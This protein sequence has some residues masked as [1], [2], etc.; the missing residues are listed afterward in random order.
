MKSNNTVIIGA[1]PAGL[2]AAL[3][4]VKKGGAPLVLEAGSEVGGIA[5]TVEYKDFRFDIGGHRFLTKLES[6]DHLWQQMLGPDFLQVKRSSRIYYNT[7]FFDYPLKVTNAL[8]NL[9]L[10]ESARII[11]SYSYSQLFPYL[12]E[13]TFEQW[14]CNR[15]GKHLYRIFFKT[16]TEKVWGIPCSAIRADWAAQRIKG[17]SMVSVDTNAL[18]GTRSAKTLTDQFQYPARGPGMMWN[19]F[20]AAV[21]GAGGKVQLESRVVGLKHDNG[22]IISLQVQGRQGVVEIPAGQVV[23]SM[24]ITTLVRSLNP[25]PPEGPPYSRH[26]RQI[27]RCRS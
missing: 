9:G 16:Y 20:L 26:P 8:G 13:K 6:I 25:A 24:P 23:S 10:L 5:R 21:T 19:R 14:M 15:F 22:R 2:S 11:L 1:G 7:R 12:D 3:E 27:R 18:F 17:L 4:L